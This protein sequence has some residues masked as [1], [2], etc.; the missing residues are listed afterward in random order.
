MSNDIESTRVAVI[1]TRASGKTTALG[2]L[3]LAAIDLAEKDE[4]FTIRIIEK[5]M[6]IRS[7]PA[8]LMK[9]KFPPS[10][11]EGDVF[12]AVLELTWKGIIRSH[13][14]KLPFADTSGETLQTMI[15]SFRKGMYDLKE[16]SDLEGA[17]EIHDFILQSNGFII[18][19]PVTKAIGLESSEIIDDDPDVNVAR[20]VDAIVNFKRDNP[21]SPPIKGI[22]LMFT[23]YDL[24]QHALK[25]WGMGLESEIGLKK[26]MHAYYPQTYTILENF[27][28]EKVKFLESWIEVEVDEEGNPICDEDGRYK[29]S[30]NKRK[31]RP[32]Y[33]EKSYISLIEWLKEVFAE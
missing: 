11:I 20:F 6:G 7:V 13:T 27:G 2:L 32:I 22:A 23:K 3:N 9:G 12:E 26:F 31:R 14:I 4:N 19:T 21:D 33:S 17:K 10:T 5:T 18:V 24:V 15:D 30:I 29:V 16:F 8:L 28:L 25:V 1:G